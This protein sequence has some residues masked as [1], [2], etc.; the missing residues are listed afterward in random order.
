MLVS[1]HLWCIETTLT[2]KGCLI[3]LFS[4][5][6]P[7]KE[8]CYLLSVIFP[9]NYSQLKPIYLICTWDW[10]IISTISIQFSRKKGP[11]IHSNREKT[12][13]NCTDLHI[14][15]NINRENLDFG[16]HECEHSQI[17]T[18]NTNLPSVCPVSIQINCNAVTSIRILCHRSKHQTF[19]HLLFVYSRNKQWRHIDL[20][21][22]IC[23][24]LVCWFCSFEFK[25]N[26]HELC[27]IVK[28]CICFK[29]WLKN[30]CISSFDNCSAGN[31]FIC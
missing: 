12:A 22:G 15:K 4:K 17:F 25:T 5:Q 11:E 27:T 14:S 13:R 10:H 16:Y 19:W 23:F 21:V 18:A 31:L 2:W 30:G 20:P 9:Q 6:N 7:N 3:G 8:H 1:P 29:F 24:I 28:Y 26:S